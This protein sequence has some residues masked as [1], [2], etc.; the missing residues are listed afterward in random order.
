M[1][2]A[3]GLGLIATK[4]RGLPFVADLENWLSGGEGQPP[5]PEPQPQ[6]CLPGSI[7]PMPPQ[8]GHPVHA[9]GRGR[10]GRAQSQHPN[11]APVMLDLAAMPLA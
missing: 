8:K 7:F 4:A 10:A 11:G 1:G 9:T 5:D 3:L 6:R 2:A